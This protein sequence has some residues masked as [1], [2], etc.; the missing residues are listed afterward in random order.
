MGILDLLVPDLDG[1]EGEIVER[2][3]ARRIFRQIVEDTIR[4]RDPALLEWMGTGL[5]KTSVFPVPAGVGPW[6][7][8]L[9]FAADALWRG[10]GWLVAEISALLES[11]VVLSATS[12]FSGTVTAVRLPAKS[13]L[14]ST[15]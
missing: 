14:K 9:T 10:R 4:P 12:I 5:F 1:P 6:R 3:R 8:R 7:L 13:L 15:N 11:P 2:H